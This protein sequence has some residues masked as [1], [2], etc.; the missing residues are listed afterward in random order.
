MEIEVLERR[1]TS[2]AALVLAMLLFL[3][4]TRGVAQE[5]CLSDTVN[6]RM[7]SQVIS[8]QFTGPDRT[9]RP[10]LGLPQRIQS[11]KWLRTPTICAEALRHLQ[12]VGDSLGWADYP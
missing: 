10:R 8:S 4:P 1:H 2:E 7:A 3:A 9:W 5:A 6:A 11:I 12:T